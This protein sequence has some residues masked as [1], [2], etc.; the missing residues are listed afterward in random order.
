M[1]T[2]EFAKNAKLSLIIPLVKEA[3][4]S[5]ISVSIISQK[6]KILKFESEN[7][8]FYSFADA[9]PFCRQYPLTLIK[10]K[11]AT[12]K[13]L[14]EYGLSIPKGI[15]ASSFVNAK[16]RIQR[17]ELDFPLILKPIDG[18]RAIG[19]SWNI[20]SFAQ[21]A[22]SIRSLKKIQVLSNRLKSRSFVI[23]EQFDGDEFR[24]LVL[25][26]SAIACA[27]KIPATIVG[28]GFS[29]ISELITTFN[30]KRKSDFEI[31]ID[32]VVKKMFKKKKI[33]L[34]TVPDKGEKIQLRN[35]MMLAHGGRAINYSEQISP[36]LEKICVKA[37]RAVG[38]EYAGVDILI[39]KNDH[40]DIV[41]SA[42]NIIEVNTFPGH[43]LNEAPLVEKP[44]VNVSKILLQYFLK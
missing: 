4:R 7:K 32:D 22:E 42:Y 28:N 37:A 39:K 9:L 35:D 41:P 21:L 14:A 19:V 26:N 1:N 2:L 3:E 30:K 29:T 40:K 33:S 25:G 24:V 13:M 44:T 18:L 15:R 38:L 11:D 27:K 16:K 36:E 43:I 6:H 17:N 34:N 5:D 31:I 8:F 12:K 23:E 20:V 10:N